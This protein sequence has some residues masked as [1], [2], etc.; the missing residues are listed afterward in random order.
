MIVPDT[1]V[2]IEFLKFNEPYYS[3]LKHLLEKRQVLGIS[4]VFGELLQG[5][6]T[7]RE[8]EIV[9]AYWQY[10]DKKDESNLFIDAGNYSNKNKLLSKGLGLIDVVIIQFAINNNSK[11]W[12]L[13]K[14]LISVIPEEL[15]FK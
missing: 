7:K 11:I 13:D 14:K 10:I 8:R 4:C 12:S 15:K 3:E 5:I 9:L 6:K 2:W 1:S